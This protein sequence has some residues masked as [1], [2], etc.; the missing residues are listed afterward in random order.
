ME[1]QEFFTVKDV[2][3]ILRVDQETVRRMIRRGD[4][5]HHVVC[6]GSV[7]VAAL[8]LARYLQEARRG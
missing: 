6:G 3:R 5:P 1:P 4:L 7:R 8:D 2:A